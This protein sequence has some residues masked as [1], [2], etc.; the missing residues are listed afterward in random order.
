MLN[1]SLQIVAPLLNRTPE[2]IYDL[3][4][5]SI[6]PTI[7]RFKAG[8]LEADIRESMVRRVKQAGWVFYFQI[9]FK[10]LAQ[11]PEFSGHSRASL[12]KLWSR[13]CNAVVERHPTMTSKKEVT[14]EQVEEFRG[15]FGWE[16]DEG[17]VLELRRLGERVT[18]IQGFPVETW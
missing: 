18:P 6:T 11:E 16:L 10:A 1:S 14:A 15:A 4:R 8:T 17:E 5:T 13:L 2:S 9:D 12:A 7:D 3:V